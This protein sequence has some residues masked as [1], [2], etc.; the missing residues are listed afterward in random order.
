MSKEKK[1]FFKSELFKFMFVS[2]LSLLIAIIGINNNIEREKEKI[3]RSMKSKIK[4]E[5]EDE[6]YSE[7]SNK[8][9]DTIRNDLRK[10]YRDFVK[11]ELIDS[12][13][14]DTFRSLKHQI[15]NEGPE[16]SYE[17]FESIEYKQNGEN[18]HLCEVIVKDLDKI[19]TEELEGLFRQIFVN[20]G[21]KKGVLLVFSKQPEEEGYRP[22][23]RIE[24]GLNNELLVIQD[25]NS[26]NYVANGII[27]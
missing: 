11:L 25:N 26:D 27:S 9:E 1:S 20:N 15:D 17:V 13:K 22:E 12:L 23:Y 14:E 8:F 16:L 7:L 6:L 4:S 3:Y 19:F 18:V 2:V 24:E 21:D 10:E 5:V